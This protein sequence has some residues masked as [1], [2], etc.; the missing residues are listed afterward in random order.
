MP[1]GADAGL[2]AAPGPGAACPPFA[3]PNHLA[4]GGLQQAIRHRQQ[5]AFAGAARP[6]QRHPLPGVQPQMDALQAG[7]L[8]AWHCHVAQLQHWAGLACACVEAGVAHGFPLC[9]PG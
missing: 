7:E 9:L 5:S 3:A 2:L 8:P 6:Q 1:E 4:L